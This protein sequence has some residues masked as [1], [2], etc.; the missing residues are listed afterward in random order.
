MQNLDKLDKQN[1]YKNRVINEQ[2]AEHFL[3]IT[4]ALLTSGMIMLFLLGTLASVMP[5][6]SHYKRVITRSPAV[7]WISSE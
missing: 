3:F 6:P 2:R 7:V 4:A 5:K 1:S